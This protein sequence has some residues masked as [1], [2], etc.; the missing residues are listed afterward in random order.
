VLSELKNVLQQRPAPYEYFAHSQPQAQP[1][2]QGSQEQ[3]GA[4]PLQEDT[5]LPSRGPEPEHSR[6]ARRGERFGDEDDDDDD[7]D[8]SA[9]YM[10]EHDS[11]YFHREDTAQSGLRQRVE[12]AIAAELFARFKRAPADET[13]ETP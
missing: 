2:T 4:A 10:Q 7:D 3:H 13:L 9:S 6:S 8:P 12:G 1:Q 5:A 11:S